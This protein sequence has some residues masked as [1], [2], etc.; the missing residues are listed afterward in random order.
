MQR[1]HPVGI[2]GERRHAVSL[3]TVYIF[4]TKYDFFFLNARACEAN[5]AKH[6]ARVHVPHVYAGPFVFEFEVACPQIAICQRS[7]ER[8]EENEH[9]DETTTTGTVT[10]VYEDIAAVDVAHPIDHDGDAR[11]RTDMWDKGHGVVTKG[12]TERDR[13]RVTVLRDDVR[14]ACD[15]AAQA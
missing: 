14:A 9:R 10:T 7:A 5:K 2:A 11:D 6:A 8:P 15:E 13:V 4:A 3:F 12:D 1:K